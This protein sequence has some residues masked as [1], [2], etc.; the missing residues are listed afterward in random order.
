[1]TSVRVNIYDLSS[2]NTLFRCLGLGVYH[3][4]VVVADTREYYFGCADFPESG[5]GSS[6][7]PGKPPHPMEGTFYQ[8]VDL[9]TTPLSPEECHALMRSMR[10]TPQW[11]GDSYNIVYHNCHAFS[12]DFCVTLL[13]KDNIRNFPFWVRRFEKLVQFAFSVS[14]A[15]N[16]FILPYTVEAFGRVA[17]PALVPPEP[18]P[19]YQ[20]VEDTTEGAAE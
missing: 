18:T 17:P 4:G 16:I 15:H 7:H 10:T 19:E 13:G 6:R 14:L 8:T 5:I 12:L 2:I 9:G 3:T 20:F 1:M 11:L